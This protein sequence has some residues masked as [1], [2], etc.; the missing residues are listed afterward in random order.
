[1]ESA[2]NGMDSQID[3]EAIIAAQNGDED[4]SPVDLLYLIKLCQYENEQRRLAKL[5]LRKY[6]DRM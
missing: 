5:N 6:A 2:N 3:K 1:M 4:F